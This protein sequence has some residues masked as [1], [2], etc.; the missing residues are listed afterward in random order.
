MTVFPHAA[1][2]RAA[3]RAADFPPPGPPEIALAG[4][5][6]VG[7]SSAINA[8]LGRRAPA[9]TSK[10]PGRPQTSNFYSLGEHAQLI[11][12]PGYGC[13]RLPRASRA[14]RGELGEAYL[15]SRGPRVAVVV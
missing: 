4:R 11:D 6:N 12:L 7:K 5:S 15:R 1:F 3:G 14:Q 2:L 10:H 8:I 13:A 9:R